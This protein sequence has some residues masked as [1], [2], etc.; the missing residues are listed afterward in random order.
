MK[1]LIGAF[2]VLA[3]GILAAGLYFA[4]RALSIAEN[5]EAKGAK[6][7]QSYCVACHGDQ[8]KGDGHIAYLLFPKPRDFTRGIFKLRSTISGQVPT[9]DDLVKTITNGMAGTAMP[10]FHYLPEGQIRTVVQYVKKLSQECVPGSP[11]KHYFTDAK[12]QQ[13]PVPKP[14]PPS[15]ELVAKGRGVYEQLGCVQCHGDTGKGDGISAAGLKDSWGFPIKVR[16]FT[17]GVYLGGG[18]PEDLYLRFIAGMDGTPMPSFDSTIEYLGKTDRERQEVLWGLIYYVK[19]LEVQQ[20]ENPQTPPA[21][22]IIRAVRLNDS[23]KETDLMNPSN[24]DWERIEP[25]TIPVSRLWQKDANNF[26]RIRVRAKYNSEWVAILLEWTDFGPDITNYGIQDFQDGAAIQFSL[27]NEPGFHGMGSREA[28]V[29]LW[30]W[31]AEWQSRSDRAVTSDMKQKYGNRASDSDTSTYPSEISETSGL[32]GRDAGN[33]VSMQKVTNTVEEL[34]AVGPGTLT[35]QPSKEQNIFGKGQWDGQNWRVVF[36]RKWHDD[37]Q[38]DVK[39]K[40]DK[41]FPIAFAVWNG[42]KR[43]R[44]GQKL[45]STWYSLKFEKKE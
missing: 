19:S 14:I 10:S 34:N 8:G 29:D 23:V 32:S 4:N 20:A 15:N 7:Y 11:C 38:N 6:L 30:F 22:G 40:N 21:D 24:N 45:V 41:T 12:L 18:R 28:P 25:A 37:D 33:N 2:V 27:T 39:F 13:L 43:D 17:Q 1:K 16:D 9:D 3:V 31:K 35:A 36:L 26:E 44:N 5:P 42:S